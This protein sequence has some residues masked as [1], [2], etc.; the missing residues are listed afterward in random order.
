MAKGGCSLYTILFLLFTLGALMA[1][2][3]GDRCNE[4]LGVCHAEHACKAKCTK[5]HRGGQGICENNGSAKNHCLCYHDCEI[6][7]VGL[8]GLGDCN[9]TQC[10]SDCA[11]KFPGKGATGYCFSI[12]ETNY[13]NCYCRYNC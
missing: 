4:D 8:N 7:E 1:M 11:I 5:I 12:P 2:V 13:I 3:V 6:C 10:N 9:E